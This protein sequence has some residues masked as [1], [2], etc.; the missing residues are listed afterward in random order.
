MRHNHFL[1]LGIIFFLFSWNSKSEKQN[2][3]NSYSKIDYESTSTNYSEEEEKNAENSL[4]CKFADNTY[5]A[6]VDYNNAN[7]GYSSTYTLDVEVQDCQ[8][9]QINFPNDGYLDEDH[10]SYANIDE[11][12]NASVS[13]E[14]GKTYE[15]HIDE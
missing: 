13:G 1:L 14:D 12:G 10:I 3:N 9:I 6:T 8:V 7:T 5:S 2:H 11:D 15:I 4:D